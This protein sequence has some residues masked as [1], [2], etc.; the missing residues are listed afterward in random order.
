MV[1]KNAKE[2]GLIVK[3]IAGIILCQATAF[4]GSM[5]TRPAIGGWYAELAKP[6]FNPPDWVFAPVW[7]I[8]YILMGISFGII[9]QK[10]FDRKTVRT[11]MY[12]FLMQL[13]FNLLWSII[14]FGLHQ[15]LLAFIEIILLWLL[16]LLTIIKF[17]RIS[18]PAGIILIPYIIWVSFAGVLNCFLWTLN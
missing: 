17:I 10:G 15:P 4:L 12:L 7:T 2:K 3:I 18:R 6:S 11:A 16:I 8:L 5:I 14:F 1:P 13:A 9:W